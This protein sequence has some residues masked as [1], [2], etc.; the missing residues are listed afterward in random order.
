MYIQH[1]FFFYTGTGFTQNGL[2]VFCNLDHTFQ[3]QHIMMMILRRVVRFVQSNDNDTEACS[4]IC[5]VC[6]LQCKLSAVFT[7]AMKN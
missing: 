1:F 4:E 6:S 2:L 3:I 5:T 7:Q